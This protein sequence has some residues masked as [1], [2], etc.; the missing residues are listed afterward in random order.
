MRN[1]RDTTVPV[2]AAR[3][4]IRLASKPQTLQRAGG[5]PAVRQDGVRGRPARPHGG[6]C[7]R[8]APRFD[9]VA[10]FYRQAKAVAWDYLKRYTA[11]LPGATHHETELRCDLGNGAR[12]TLYGADDP[13][14]LRGLYL[15]GVVLDEY[16]QMRS[17]RLERGDPSGAGR[18][19]GLG[20]LHRHADGAQRACVS[21]T[22]APRRRPGWRARLYRAGETGMLDGG[23]AG[24]GRRSMMSEEEYAQE[25]ECSFDAAIRG[26]YYGALI[27]AAEAEERIGRVAHWSRGC[28]CT[29]P[30]T[31]ASTT[32]RRSGSA[33]GC[34]RRCG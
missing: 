20:R 8:A 1:D 28:R 29:R 17:A 26:A 32:R 4:S 23:G 18:S 16:A 14:S 11:N 13:D 3:L 5:A 31:S 24:G 34:G 30:G 33:S 27:A 12:I 7:K 25:F 9:Y 10:P 19:P 22:S 15:D 6:R 2:R 21:S